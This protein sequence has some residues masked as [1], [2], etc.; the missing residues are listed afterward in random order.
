M[1]LPPQPRLCLRKLLVRQGPQIIVFVPSPDRD[2]HDLHSHFSS[3]IDE[4]RRIATAEQLAKQ[5]EDI[6]VSKHRVFGDGLQR[7]WIFHD[8]SSLKYWVAGQL[9]RQS[10]KST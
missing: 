9:P 2:P 5:D 7:D 8:F 10:F 4:A 1:I 6:A 3:L